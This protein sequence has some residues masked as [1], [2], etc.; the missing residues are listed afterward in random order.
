MKKHKLL[1][2]VLVVGLAAQFI[3]CSPQRPHF[4]G[5]GVRPS[6]LTPQEWIELGH[7]G[8]GHKLLE[9]FVGDWD[10][11]VSVRSA[12]AAP[13]SKSAARSSSRWILGGRF[14]QEEFAGQS[15]GERYEGI[16]ILGYD[17][18]AEQFTSVWMDSLTTAIATARGRYFLNEHRFEFE[19]EVYDPLKGGRKRTHTTIE[20]RSHD[21]YVLK[22]IDRLPNGREFAALE[23]SYRRRS[24]L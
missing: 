10:A 23:I 5:D 13:V 19:G 18:G 20:V 1:T 12:P 22:M 4:G 24:S 11:E 14:I 3:G 16:G 8:E 17:N 15:G 2:S 21:H 7:P 9:T 6:S